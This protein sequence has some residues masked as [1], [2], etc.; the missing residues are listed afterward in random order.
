MIDVP[1]FPCGQDKKPL[2]E[3][4][5]KDAT[6]DEEQIA[7]WWRRW[8]DANTARPTGAVSGIVVIDADL[9]KPGVKEALARL[10]LPPTMMIKTPRGGIHL[11]FRHPGTG[12]RILNSA[13]KLGTGIDVRG[14]GGYVLIPPSSIGGVPYEHVPESGSDIEELPEHLAALIVEKAKPR[15]NG[16]GASHDSEKWSEGTRNDQMFRLAASLRSRGLPEEAILDSLRAVNESQC[17]PPLSEKELA[18]I[19]HSAGRYEQGRTEKCGREAP[20]E[21]KR[22]TEL[23]YASFPEVL[24]WARGRGDLAYNSMSDRPEIGDRALRDTDASMLR[25]KLYAQGLKCG[26]TMMQECID[27]VTAENAYNPLV[28]YMNGLVWDGTERLSMLLSRVLGARDSAYT[29]EVSKRFFTGAAQRAIEPGSDHR[30][31]LV[32]I[33]KESIGKSLFCKDLCIKREWYTDSLPKD[34]HSQAASEAVIGMQ[35][36][37]SSEMASMRHT[38]GESI[39]AFISRTHEKF[40]HA[41]GRY[42]IET[43]RQ[44]VIIATTNTEFPIP[45]DGEQT[46]M[47]PVTVERYDREYLLKNK[48]QIW[49]EAAASYR[50]GFNWREMPDEVQKAVAEAR[51]ELRQSDEWEPCLA[52]LEGRTTLRGEQQLTMGEAR[53]ALD[54]PIRDFTL[55]N[56]MRVGTILLRLGWRRVRVMEDGKRSYVY[57]RASGW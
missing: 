49:A 22:G 27:L 19:A 56:Q 57:R 50:S 29:R 24:A 12:V 31:M 8:P 14:D 6:T 16:N 28:D 36:I 54:I 17:I 18:T 7:S 13:G 42:I 1:I 34:L 38:D 37:E 51:E 46:R 32:L 52:R 41:Y 21:G 55:K 48:D 2:T 43:P 53:A 10:R 39:K 40:R 26:R 47:W 11:Y 35:I 15:S 20:P 45:W 30:V 4:G 9:Y 23:R 5:L 33:G 3:H 25:E 44:S